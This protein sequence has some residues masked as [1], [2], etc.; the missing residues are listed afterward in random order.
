MRIPSRFLGPEGYWITQPDAFCIDCTALDHDVDACSGRLVECSAVR[1]VNIGGQSHG[2]TVRA[3]D[4]IEHDC[5]V[6]LGCH[7]GQFAQVLGAARSHAIGKFCQTCLAAKGDAFDLKVDILLR[8]RKQEIN[9]TFF[10]V[11][12]LWTDQIVGRQIR[13]LVGEQRGFQHAIGQG[14]IDT[15]K[16][17]VFVV[18]KTP[19]EFQLLFWVVIWFKPDFG[20]RFSKSHHRTRIG[21]MGGHFTSIDKTDIGQKTFVA[22]D[23]AGRDKRRG[24]FHN[25]PYNHSDKTGEPPMPNP[26]AA[27]LVIGDEILSGRTRDANMHYLAGQLTERGIDLKEVR[28]VSDDRDAIV[29]A[30]KALSHGYVHVFTSGG[31]GPTHDDITADCIAAAFDLAIDVRDDARALLQA[32]YD[33]SGQELNAARLRMARIPDG[34]TLIDNP[35]STAPGFSLGNVHVMAGVPTVFQAMIA[36]ILPTLTGGAPLL[37]RTLRL[38]MGEGDIAELLGE[39]AANYSDLSVGS[40]PFQKGG[41]YG[42]N[43][44]VRGSDAQQLDKA[45]AVLAAVFDQ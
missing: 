36:S 38:V 32:H 19:T 17:T 12:H 34:A 3:L 11:F 44:V 25:P 42:S 35:V 7:L 41:L 28:V 10:A 21:A 1:G 23:Q 33:R 24:K 40:Y 22:F 29:A 18:D 8:T 27:M 14:C 39:F 6:P 13:H 5:A 43:I 9:T 30:V 31:I 26:S 45:M 20:I 37:S 15:R 4:Q 2:M 16:M